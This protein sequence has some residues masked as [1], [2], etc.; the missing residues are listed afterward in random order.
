MN[1]SAFVIAIALALTSTSSASKAVV[2]HGSPGKPAAETVF[3]EEPISVETP[4]GTLYGTLERPH[5]ASP[6]PVALIIAGSGPTDRDGNSV[7]LKGANNSLK[8]LAEGLAARGIASVRYDK[9]GVGETGKAMLLAAE[10]AKTPLREDDLRFETYID[11][12][13]LWGKTLRADRRFS[14]LTVIGH[15]E[16]SLIGM[17]AAQRMGA[18]GYVSIAGSGRPVQQ[19]ILEQV[20]SRL[21][22]DLLKPAEDI[23]GQLAAGKTVESVPPALNVLFRSSV[24]PYLISWFRYDPAGEIAKLHIP[25][26][27]VQGTTDMQTSLRDAKALATANSGATLLLVG[28]MNHV[29]KT[30]PDEQ[31]RQISSYSDPTLPVAPRLIAE[32]SRFVNE[33]VAKKASTEDVPMLFRGSMPAV[34]VRGLFCSRLTPR[35]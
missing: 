15:S 19:L 3:T 5:S 23:L 31:N 9:R 33:A 1:K 8:L 26:L 12:A 13:V 30:V 27:I 34:E 21:P 10:K 14:T 20:K 25:A 16:G 22:P 28:G 35:T 32:I 29:L 24:Q 7:M 6:V 17:V 4:T 2:Q 11:D 18:H